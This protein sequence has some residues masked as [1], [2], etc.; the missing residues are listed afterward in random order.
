M[1]AVLGV[2]DVAKSLFW[3]NLGAVLRLAVR[4]KEAIWCSSTLSTRK[5]SKRAGGWGTCMIRYVRGP[6]NITSM[7]AAF[8]SFEG[9]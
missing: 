5:G 8:S 2:N 4:I 1:M 7:S 3:S 9:N 6:T